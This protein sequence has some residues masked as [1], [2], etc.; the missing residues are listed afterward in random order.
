MSINA[1]SASVCKPSLLCVGEEI[2]K[3]PPGSWL[4][5]PQ[6]PIPSELPQSTDAQEPQP[7]SYNAQFPDNRA[8]P[9]YNSQSWR[10][11]GTGSEDDMLLNAE[12][13]EDEDEMPPDY[14]FVVHSPPEEST[15]PGNDS[16]QASQPPAPP[17]SRSNHYM[18]QN[19]ASPRQSAYPSD[20][21]DEEGPTLVD[22]NPRTGVLHIPE[23][24]SMPLLGSVAE[25]RRR[26]AEEEED[27]SMPSSMFSSLM[28]RQ[29]SQESCEPEDGLVRME[30]AWQLQVN[31]DE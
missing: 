31:M 18:A 7:P 1:I 14:G 3:P 4:S 30:T 8:P 2:D 24:S 25:V 28:V 27:M 6:S 13:Q 21:D 11:S 19:N 15:G 20:P 26:A 10:S 23:I 12:I 5:I 9:V 22:W 16:V 29:P 17:V